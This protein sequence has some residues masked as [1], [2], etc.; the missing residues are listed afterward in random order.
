AATPAPFPRRRARAASHRSATASRATVAASSA[1]GREPS[2]PARKDLARAGCLA[3]RRGRR[4]GPR[5][6]RRRRGRRAPG[7]A[8]TTSG[9]G[10]RSAPPPSL[11]QDLLGD[12]VE[13]YVR[14]AFVD[15][16]DLRIAEELLGGEVLGE[17][18]AA[19]DLEGERG[20]ALG[21]LR[22][23]VLGHRS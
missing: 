5:A 12:R 9:S 4:S 17:P 11:F 20:H 23:I 6:R 21:D 15:L 22:G 2:R 18:V 3:S 16:T 1:P 10:A 8:E 13:L 7:A 14:G 19:E